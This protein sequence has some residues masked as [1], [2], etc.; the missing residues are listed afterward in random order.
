MFCYPPSAGLPGLQEH[1]R[2]MPTYCSVQQW[3]S[4]GVLQHIKALHS[5][6]VEGPSCGF[7]QVVRSS[8]AVV[9]QLATAAAT[10]GFATHLH[11]VRAKL[12]CYTV[13]CAA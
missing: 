3:C 7:G 13:F 8:A 10:I 1:C 9:Q 12:R 4:R 2:L 5:E 6:S 11:T